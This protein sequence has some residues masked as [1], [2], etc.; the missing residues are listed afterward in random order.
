MSIYKHQEDHLS[1]SSRRVAVG[2]SGLTEAGVFGPPQ[3]FRGGGK[4]KTP[5]FVALAA[6]LATLFPVAGAQAQINCVTDTPITGEVTTVVT[7]NP[8][9]SSNTIV[10]NGDQTCIIE[11]TAN[12]KPLTK[13]DTTRAVQ[14]GGHNPKVNFRGTIYLRNIRHP[15]YSGA[16]A[17]HSYIAFF[18]TGPGSK[19]TVDGGTINLPEISSSVFAVQNGANNS[20]IEFLSGSASLTNTGGP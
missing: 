2:L 11:S 5:L 16:G 4:Y 20:V 17:G 14:L 15:Q 7:G 8:T 18:I 9:T 6:I 12:I 3:K 19:V 1:P 10:V 13:E